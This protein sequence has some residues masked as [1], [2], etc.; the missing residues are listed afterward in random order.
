MVRLYLQVVMRPIYVLKLR[1]FYSFSRV[2]VVS[3]KCEWSKFVLALKY[4]HQCSMPYRV[5]TKF[6]QV[7]VVIVELEGQHENTKAL[8]SG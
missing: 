6:H 7:Y 8:W 2:A 3:R 1:K 4:Y 5:N